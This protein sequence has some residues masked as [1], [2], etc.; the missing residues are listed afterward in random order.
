M[1][2]NTTALN[3]HLAGEVTTMCTCWKVVLRNGT[4]YGFTDHVRNITFNGVTYLAAAG[5]T[6]SAIAT[7][8]DLSVDNLEVQGLLSSPAITEADLMAGLWDYAN[9]EVFRLN[10]TDLTMGAESLR[11]GTIGEVTALRSHFLAEMRGVSQMLQQP[12]GE[13]YSLTCRASLGDARCKFNV[14]TL[15]VSGTVAAVNPDNRTI[16]D[17]A[18]TEPGPPGSVAIVGISQANPGQVAT[19][20]AHGL[21]NGQVVLITDVV[22]MTDFKTVNGTNYTGEGSINGAVLQVTVTGTNTFTIN[23]TLGYTPYVSGG[24]VSEPRSVGYFDSGL[25]TFTSG[26]NAGLSME[27]KAYAPGCITL[28]LPMPYVIDVGDAYTLTPGCTKRF[29]EDCKAKFNN[30]VNFRGEP[31]VPGMDKMLRVGGM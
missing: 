1:K 19:A 7:T 24:H 15:R 22:G 12:L 17:P 25:I 20:T 3:A 9:I 13:I 6:P 10:Y 29:A 14:N 27:V 21:S 26:A 8:G 2:S 28:Q 30:V 31:H 5:Y 4:V 18:R 11:A 16:F 23:N